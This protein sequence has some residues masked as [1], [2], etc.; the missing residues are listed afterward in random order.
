MAHKKKYV[1]KDDIE[2]YVIYLLSKFQWDFNT[3]KSPNKIWE[4]NG[5]KK[6]GLTKCNFERIRSVLFLFSSVIIPVIYSY[7]IPF[8]FDFSMLC[9]IKESFL[10]FY[11]SFVYIHRI[12]STLTPYT[13][14]H[15]AFVSLH[16]THYRTIVTIY[17]FFFFFCYTL[18][19]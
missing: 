17:L 16:F 9:S 11:F 3:I 1:K 10:L 4:W 13:L 7:F 14:S 18:L 2:L 8:H 12:Y 19:I 5:R 6:K 15:K